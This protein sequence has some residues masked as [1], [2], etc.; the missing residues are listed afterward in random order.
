MSLGLFGVVGFIRGR[1]GSHWGSFGSS[2][3]VG[4]TQG[5]R[6]DRLD[7]PGFAVGVF[8]RRWVHMR[9]PWV[10]FGS[11]V[12]VGFFQ[13]HSGDLW[14]HPESMSSFGCALGVIGGSWFH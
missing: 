9:Y 10:S 11:L 14:V 7:S 2:G 13:V 5:S 12:F 1:W 6:G 3:V 4:F 8:G